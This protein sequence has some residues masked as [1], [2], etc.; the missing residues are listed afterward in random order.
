V[1]SS[2]HGGQHCAKAASREADCRL[3]CWQHVLLL[4]LLLLLLG[5][6]S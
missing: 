3:V 2:K 1:S 5:E 6:G 4:L